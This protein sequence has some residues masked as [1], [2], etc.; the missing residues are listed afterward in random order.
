MSAASAL[1]RD[2]VDGLLC[3]PTTASMAEALARLL[4]DP[5][6][7]ASMSRS[8]R[9]AAL[10]YDWDLLAA[11]ME[12]VYFGAARRSF[13]RHSVLQ[14]GQEFLRLRIERA[15]F[16]SIEAKHFLGQLHDLFLEEHHALLVSHRR[17][18]ERPGER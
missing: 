5:A 2:G 4:S 13:R 6:R 10:Q 7:L 3:D 12:E 15:D 8:A 11:R 16:E 17:E 14:Q 9:R 18:P 1:V